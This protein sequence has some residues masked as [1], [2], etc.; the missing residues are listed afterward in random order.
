M[1]YGFKK[2]IVEQYKFGELVPAAIYDEF[3]IKAE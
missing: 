2:D 1:V 3:T